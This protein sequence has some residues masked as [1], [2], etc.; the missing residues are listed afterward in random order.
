MAAAVAAAPRGSPGET[1]GETPGETPAHSS[2][3]TLPP[4]G[5][6]DAH[7]K[8]ARPAAGPREP[9]LVDWCTELALLG[10]EF[11]A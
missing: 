10:R 7:G 9:Q 4:A 3:P 8:R 1:A 5:A 11:R 6:V 2:G